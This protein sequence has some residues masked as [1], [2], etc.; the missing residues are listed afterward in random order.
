MTMH[1]NGS[2]SAEEEYFNTTEA[3]AGVE[4]YAA[5]THDFVVF[6][7]K[8]GRRIVLVTSGGTTVPLENQTVRFIDNFSAGTRGATSAEYFMEKGYAVIFMHRQF[9]LQP[10]S[11]H[12]SHSKNCFLDFLQ[13][14]ETGGI[15]VTPEYVPKMKNV[16]LKY[17]EVRKNNLLL[18]IEFITVRD[19]LF[20]LRRITQIVALARENAMYYL[21]AA[22]SDFYIPASKMVEHKIQSGDG[23]LSL[24]LEQV[25]KIIKPLVKE[26]ATRGLIISFKL[27]TDPDILEEKARRALIRYGHQIVIGNILATRKNIVHLITKDDRVDIRLSPEEAK[28]DVEIESKIIPELVERHT[29]WIESLKDDSNG[30]LM[31]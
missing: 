28:Q 9:S 3:P 15:A 26:W 21:A 1:A 19:Y 2:F 17:Q 25:P 11:R 22:V 12:Y 29:R 24:Q 18:N 8:A 14:D 13:V 27:E 7:Q 5:K 16:L 30:H 10:Y 4:E 31:P 23:A 20:L 6:H